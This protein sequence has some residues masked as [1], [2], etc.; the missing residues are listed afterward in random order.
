MLKENLVN[1]KNLRR[2]QRGFTLIELLIVIIIIAILAAVV[3]PRIIGRTEDAKISAAIA[4]ISSFQSQ[5]N[6]YN[7]DIG[8]F[9]TA[10][11]GLQGL[12]TNPGNP[13]WKG[14][15]LQ[16]MEKVKM[17]PWGHPYIYKQPGDG[18]RDFDILSAGPD[19]QVGTPDDIQ[20]W[21]LQKQ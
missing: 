19:G 1:P 4:D 2:T 6:I 12:V 5:L 14:P 16:G 13:K 15:Y 7:A 18:N 11:Q 20:S 9:P 17:D 10:D 8:T 21:N 3:I